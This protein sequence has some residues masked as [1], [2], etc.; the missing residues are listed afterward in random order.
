MGVVSLGLA[1]QLAPTATK[2]NKSPPAGEPL[3]LLKNS[4]SP[5]VAA[6]WCEPSA[7]R[8]YVSM[9]RADPVHHS[10][11]CLKSRGADFVVSEAQREERRRKKKNPG[12]RPPSGQ[13]LRG[14]ARLISP[15]ASQRRLA[16]LSVSVLHCPKSPKPA[17]AEASPSRRRKFYLFRASASGF[18]T[19]PVRC[20]HLIRGSCVVAKGVFFT[21]SR[22]P[23]L[24]TE[25]GWGGA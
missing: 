5:N 3:P 14:L 22:Q 13:L 9:Q 15:V 18:E 25:G 17:E 16:S 4:L 6:R 20:E 7:P 11:S 10:Q 2:K 12:P 1:S 23:A 24:R 21:E 8:L 19:T